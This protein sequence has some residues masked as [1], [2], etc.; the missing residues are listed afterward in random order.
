V[1]E[2]ITSPKTS[3]YQNSIVFVKLSL[4]SATENHRFINLR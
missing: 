4:R 2:V 1:A 3:N